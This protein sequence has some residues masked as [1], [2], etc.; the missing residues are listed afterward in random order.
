MTLLEVEGLT[1]SFGGIKA[2]QG[3]SFSVDEGQILGVIG[4]NGAGKT[5]LFNLITGFLSPDRGVVKLA[6][7]S[8]T[9]MRPDLI[10]RRGLARTFQISEPM[11]ALTVEEAVRISAYCRSGIN[12]REAFTVAAEVMERVGL[13][14][15]SQKLTSSL[16]S[17]E[18][19]RLE[20]ARALAAG[21][22]MILLDELAA[23]LWPEEQA[24]LV[25]L[26][27]EASRRD[28]I[29]FLI[30]EHKLSFLQSVA[31]SSI[32]INFGQKIAEGPPAEVLRNSEVEKAYLGSKE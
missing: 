10:A 26:I 32:V 17:A 4:P 30:V 23:G 14:D 24:E 6:G 22:R 11:N 25:R 15:N 21:P 19:H 7:Q 8:I 18:I 31:D 28:G 9:G 20:F 12:R 13:L 3:V 16:T 2:M 1:K 27:T 5:T 29:A